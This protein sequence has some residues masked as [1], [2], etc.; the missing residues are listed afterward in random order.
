L[1]LRLGAFLRAGLAFIASAHLLPRGS[2]DGLPG[3]K[4]I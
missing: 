4:R 3:P 2:Y 1:A